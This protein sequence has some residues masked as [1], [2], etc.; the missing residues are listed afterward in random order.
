M[1]A[2]I[3]EEDHHKIPLLHEYVQVYWLAPNKDI[4]VVPT[5]D[6]VT[7]YDLRIKVAAGENQVEL[8]HQAFCKWYLKLY[9]A[10]PRTLIYLWASRIH[11]EEGI[12]IKN[13]MDIPMVFPLLK[14]F[15]HILLLCMMGGA[16]HVQVL[17]GTDLGLENIM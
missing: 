12:W 7:H 3:G 11:D 10:D 5:R 13:P 4:D 9:K 2:A 8:F 15:V 1:R 17:L 14:M 6:F 16:Y